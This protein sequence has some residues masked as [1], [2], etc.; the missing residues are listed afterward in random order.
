MQARPEGA[1]V[2]S[3]PK[4][5]ACCPPTA[6]LLS[7]SLQVLPPI[8]G[9][10]AEPRPV[11]AAWALLE[12]LGLSPAARRAGGRQLGEREAQ[13]HGGSGQR[14]H[15]GEEGETTEEYHDAEEE[16]EYHDRAE[17]H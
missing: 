5:A 11:E 14:H 6:P 10:T 12:S 13:G 4:A 15:H 16:G 3:P 17:Q 9:G 7:A 2:P 8:L 1:A